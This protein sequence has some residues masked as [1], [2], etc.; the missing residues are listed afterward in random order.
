MNKEFP[1]TEKQQKIYDF[2]RVRGFG[3]ATAVLGNLNVS[4]HHDNPRHECL[5]ISYIYLEQFYNQAQE[6][7]IAMMQKIIDSEKERCGEAN[8]VT[9]WV[10]LKEQIIKQKEVK[11]GCN[12]NDDACLRFYDNKDKDNGGN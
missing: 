9:C 10:M 4:L 3:R 7:I 1:Q 2:W 6:D 11:S 12:A 5:G 8:A